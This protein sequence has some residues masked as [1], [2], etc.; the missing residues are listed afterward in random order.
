MNIG[1]V[2]AGRIGTFHARSLAD[3]PRVSELRITDVDP[4]RAQSLATG[5]GAETSADAEEL[6]KWADALVIA[7]ATDAH[8]ELRT[9]S[10]RRAP[11][12]LRETDIVGSDCYRPCACRGR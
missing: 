3:D 5:L 4:A 7:T 8:A 6:A 11:N 10:A 1:L 2:G 9:G 12:V